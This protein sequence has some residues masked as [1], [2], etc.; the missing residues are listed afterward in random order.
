MDYTFQYFQMNFDYAF[1]LLTKNN[2]TLDIFVGPSGSLIFNSYA[3]G[4]G[5][6]P[7]SIL[8][9]TPNG[10][11]FY[12]TSFKKWEITNEKSGGIS[13]FN[14]G[15]N[16][17]LDFHFPIYKN[18]DCLIQNRNTLF[19]N[20][21]IFSEYTNLTAYIKSGLSVGLRYRI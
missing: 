20:R 4:N 14:L 8:S 17:G 19:V 1:N 10:Q 9:F 16:F 13:K 21:Q 3:S 6:N 15:I 18:L 7:I 11:P 12:T 2:K 5:Y